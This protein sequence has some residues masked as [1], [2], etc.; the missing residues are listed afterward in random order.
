MSSALK[1]FNLTDTF[2]GAGF[3]CGVEFTRQK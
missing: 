1:I 3:F 2:L